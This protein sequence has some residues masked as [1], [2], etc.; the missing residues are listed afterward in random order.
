MY[1]AKSHTR[2]TRSDLI[3]Y[4]NTVA[5]LFTTDIYTKAPLLV[6][7]ESGFCVYNSRMYYV[8]GHGD[9]QEMTLPDERYRSVL[10]AQQLL[11]DLLDPKTTPR[12]PRE[13]RDR[14][15]HCLRHYPGSWDMHR[16]A[17]GAPEVFQEQMEDLTRFIQKGLAAR[18]DPDRVE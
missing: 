14:A 3:L 18:G 8:D 7:D 5:P 11:R 9:C 4:S 13:I 16:A 6:V 10:M 17:E 12:I 1:C 15:R 2:S